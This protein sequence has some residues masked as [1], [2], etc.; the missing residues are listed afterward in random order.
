[1]E[2]LIEMFAQMMRVQMESH[3]KNKERFFQLFQGNKEKEEENEEKQQ[4]F[5]LEL[6]KTTRSTFWKS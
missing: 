4:R 5:F 1:M 6:Q 3:Q 2:D